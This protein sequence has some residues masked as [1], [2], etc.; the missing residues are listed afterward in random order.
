MEALIKIKAQC[1]KR[2]SDSP[3]IQPDWTSYGVQSFTI[4]LDMEMLT[5]NNEKC[6][7]TFKKMLQ[8]MSNEDF[9]YQY[10]NYEIAEP[11][12]ITEKEFQ[13]IYDKL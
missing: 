1:L 6:I 7:L 2:Q 11:V 9:K 10:I 5:Q 13:Q 8:K 4:F 3:R 12:R